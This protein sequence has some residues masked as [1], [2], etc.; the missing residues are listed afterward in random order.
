MVDRVRHA[1]AGSRLD[2]RTT[3][4]LDVLG[5]L[6]PGQSVAEATQALR[7]AQPQIRE[8]TMPERRHPRDLEEYLR[9]GFTLVPAANGFSEIRGEY[10]RPLLTV[11]AVVVLV[12][13]IA[14]VNLASLLLARANARRHELGARLAL[15][16]SRARLLQQ[17]ATETL[18]LAVPGGLLGLALA[19]WGS[20]I[21]VGQIT[22][23]GGPASGAPVSLDLSLHWRVLLFTLGVTL[24]TAL[25][26]GIV[27]ALRAGRL[28][29]RDAIEWRRRGLTGEGPGALGGPLVVTQLALSLVLVFG[30]GLF[31][32]TFA[33][34]AYRDLGLESDGILLVNLDAQRSSVR[35]EQRAALLARAEEAVGAMPGV[36][37]AAVSFMNPVSGMGWNES[38]EVEG[39]PPPSGRD[40]VSWLNAVSPGWFETYGVQRLAGRDFDGRDRSGAPFVAVVNQAFARRFL[41]DRSPIGRLLRPG[42]PSGAMPPRVIVGL[43]EDTVYRSPRDAMEPIVYVPM[44]QGMDGDEAWPFA[45]LG[46]RS[47]GGSP[48]LLTRDV[49]AVIAGVDPAVSLSFRVFSEQVGASVMRERLMAWLSAFFGGLAL[50]LAGIGIYGVTAYGVSRRRTEIG[51]RMALGAQAAAVVRLVLG[52]SFTL[53]ALGLA[54]GTAASL[55]LSR[56]VAALLYGFEPGDPSTLA[57]AAAAL[58]GVGLL[59]AGLPA[60]RAAHIDPARV[61]REG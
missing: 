19:G 31:L 21:L 37:R 13:L 3:W 60:R 20:R 11:M 50:L 14:C 51:V 9:E 49:A 7:L 58:A 29:P 34:L 45:T 42:G 23:P 4:W 47:A 26:F 12:L 6:K 57:A 32:R 22:G 30:A 54:L 53:V 35:P 5:R 55:W 36:A 48:S 52:R 46:V 43:V 41:G 8:A 27:P 28:S 16:A 38:F 24:V 33:S 44:A 1:P 39:V 18:L 10:E 61:L 40:R 17:L 15:G 56:F 25:L 2:G 59:A